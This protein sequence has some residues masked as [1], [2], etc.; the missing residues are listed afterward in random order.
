MENAHIIDKAALDSLIQKPID[1]NKFKRSNQSD[2][3][4]PYFRAELTKW[5]KDLFNKK[6][7]VKS[8]GTEY[9][10]YKDGLKIY[11][12]HRFKLSKTG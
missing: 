6:H 5:L 4:A 10:V 9:N 2:G 11:N 3:P 12:D 1:T 7:I 8:D